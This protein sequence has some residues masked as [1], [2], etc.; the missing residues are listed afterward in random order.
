MIIILIIL[1]YN[2]ILKP[3]DK[4][5][6]PRKDNSIEITGAVQQYCDDVRSGDFPNQE[7]S[8]WSNAP[9]SIAP[10]RILDAIPNPC[11]TPYLIGGCSFFD[12][13]AH[14]QIHTRNGIAILK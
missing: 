9:I 14:C 11:H 10:G 3:S 6:V 13:D 1:K 12:H 7:E 4:I 2:V 8:Y 5:I